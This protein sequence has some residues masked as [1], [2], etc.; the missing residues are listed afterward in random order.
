MKEYNNHTSKL[1]KLSYS[2]TALAA[3]NMA[4]A[5]SRA[6]DR[7]DKITDQMT[8]VSEVRVNLSQHLLFNDGLF[9][10]IIIEALKS[11]L[12]GLLWNINI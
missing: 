1:C 11:V 6:A 3:Q 5:S 12:F 4:A 7:F 9:W 10:K 2:G 8:L